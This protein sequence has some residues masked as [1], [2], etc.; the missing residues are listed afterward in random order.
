[1]GRVFTLPCAE[2]PTLSVGLIPLTHD[3]PIMMG[4]S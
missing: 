1:M 3:P 4:G 2:A